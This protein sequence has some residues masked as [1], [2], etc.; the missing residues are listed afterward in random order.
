MKKGLNYIIIIG[1]LFFIGFT[2]FPAKLDYTD[3][4]K[5]I[6]G[7]SM[8]AKYKEAVGEYWKDKGA[9]PGA[10]EWAKYDKKI[11]I[12]SGKSLV[13]SI[14]IGED[15]PGTISIYYTNTRDQGAPA[16][17]A[18]TRIVLTPEVKDRKLVWSCKGTL[19][20]QY[21]PVPCR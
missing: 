7:L 3:R 1:L 20:S 13:D 5:V 9:L 2:L 16:D 19:P 12:E 8:G 15:G 14:H 6:Q 11:V 18:G 10:E 17:I 4:T 21:L